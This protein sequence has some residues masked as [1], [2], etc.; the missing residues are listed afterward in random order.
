MLIQQ[1]Q[2]EA[3]EKLLKEVQE[4][5]SSLNVAVLSNLA[6]LYF[7]QGKWNE[8]LKELLQ[9]EQIQ[10]QN[11]FIKEQLAIVYHRLGNIEKQENLSMN[12]KKPITPLIPIP[13]NNRARHQTIIF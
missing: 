11:Y 4:K 5:D 1:N 3:A 8:S 10:P 13:S 12:V 7:S 6:S 2:F 9:L